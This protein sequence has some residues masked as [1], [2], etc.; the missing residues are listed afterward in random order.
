MDEKTPILTDLAKSSDDSSM[1]EFATTTAAAGDGHEKTTTTADEAAPVDKNLDSADD[2]VDDDAVM[3]DD[4]VARE[5]ASQYLPTAAA[6]VIMDPDHPAH[7]AGVGI[8]DGQP[9]TI[10]TYV[11]THFREM[12]GQ[13]PACRPLVARGSILPTRF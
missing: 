3:H 9:R 11:P 4:D 10:G 1:D 5:A 8:P 12:P 2:S 7:Q 6:Y 13:H